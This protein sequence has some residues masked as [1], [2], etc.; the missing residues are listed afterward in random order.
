MREY[1][2]SRAFK[3]RGGINLVGNLG[4][5]ERAVGIVSAATGNH[6]QSLAYAG[7]LFDVPVTIYGPARM[8]TAIK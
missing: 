3:V 1:A 2:A 6:G 5:E 4:A 7:Y 8:P